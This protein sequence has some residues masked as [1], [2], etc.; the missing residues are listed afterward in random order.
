MALGLTDILPQGNYM[1][2][3]ALSMN[4]TCIKTQF[5]LLVRWKRGCMYSISFHIDFILVSSR[6]NKCSFWFEQYTLRY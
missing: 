3:L 4:V 5:G 1:L 6:E 2:Y